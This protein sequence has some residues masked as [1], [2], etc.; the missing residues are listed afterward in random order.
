MWSVFHTKILSLINKYIP[1]CIFKP[2]SKPKWLDSSTLR[3]I[4]KKH[5]AWNTYKATRRHTDF[6]L[7]TK[8]RNIATSSIRKAKSTF[9][10]NLAI[11]VKHNPS[12]FWKYVRNNAKVHN[13]AIALSQEDG[14]LTS[15]DY[16]TANTFNKFFPVC[17]LLSQLQI[18]HPWV[19]DLKGIVWI[20]S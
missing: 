10:F 20:I 18:Y 9:E 2:N 17:L 6:I 13:D 3:L 12:L 11:N 1:T 14:S 15:S 4:K 7:Y 5:K 19:I 16:E 8:S